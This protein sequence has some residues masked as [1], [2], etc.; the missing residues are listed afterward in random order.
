MSWGYHWRRPVTYLRCCDH[1][2]FR[3]CFH[4]IVHVCW[5]EEAQPKNLNFY[6]FIS[7]RLPQSVFS[8]SEP[9]FFAETMS[10][11]VLLIF[12]I[13]SPMYL[14]Y[15]VKTSSPIHFWWRSWPWKPFWSTSII[16]RMRFRIQFLPDHVMIHSCL[17]W[18][19]WWLRYGAMEP[20]EAT[21][22]RVNDDSPEF[23]IHTF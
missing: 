23:W 11:T 15:F 19:P 12:W 9:Q 17:V 2:L 4:S 10:P 20:F 16:R 13:I 14:D 3:V 8:A 5:W 22:F 7:S 18:F 1:L 21:L 6:L